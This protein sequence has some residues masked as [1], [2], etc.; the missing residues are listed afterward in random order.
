MTEFGAELRVKYP[1]AILFRKHSKAVVVSDV[2]VCM[3]EELSLSLKQRQICICWG[4]KKISLRN[5]K[6]YALDDELG[7]LLCQI[8]SRNCAK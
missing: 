5:Y 7:I 4:K 1:Q 3:G 8:P 6:A 2:S